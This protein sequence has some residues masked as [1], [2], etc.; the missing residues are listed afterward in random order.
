MIWKQHTFYMFNRGA[1]T[2]ETA[3]YIFPKE[4]LKHFDYWIGG[5][6]ENNANDEIALTYNGNDNFTYHHVPY[7]Y[8]YSRYTQVSVTNKI[9]EQLGRIL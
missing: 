8:Q 6:I 1:I 7:W 4:T 9:I 2:E 3:P 5:V